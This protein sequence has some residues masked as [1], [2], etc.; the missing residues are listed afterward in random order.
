MGA[1]MKIFIVDPRRNAPVDYDAAS[2]ATVGLIATAA[3]HDFGITTG[4]DLLTLSHSGWPLLRSAKIAS[5]CKEGTTY[6]IRSI[7]S[8]GLMR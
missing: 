1:Q 5:V 3:A 6:A 7:G 8:I 4:D 2:D